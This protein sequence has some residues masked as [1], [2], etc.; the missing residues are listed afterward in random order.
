MGLNIGEHA[1]S[2]PLDRLNAVEEVVRRP[3]F[4]L[5]YISKTAQRL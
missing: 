3:G 4:E 1:A 2:S 5:L